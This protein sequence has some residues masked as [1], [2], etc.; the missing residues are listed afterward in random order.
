M[1]KVPVRFKFTCRF[2][3]QYDCIQHTKM[4]T[5]PDLLMEVEKTIIPKQ[6]IAYNIQLGNIKSTPKGGQQKDE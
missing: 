2:C 1:G 5:P 6:V 4:W 3:G